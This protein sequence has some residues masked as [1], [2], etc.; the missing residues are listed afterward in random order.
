MAS[1]AGAPDIQLLEQG[2]SS[3]DYQ[4][5]EFTLTTTSWQ[6][7]EIS[8]V[9]E[10][11]VHIVLMVGIAGCATLILFALVDHHIA[12][13]IVGAFGCLLLASLCFLNYLR[14]CFGLC[15]SN[16]NKLVFNENAKAVQIF[17]NGAF[18]DS[19]AFEEY[20][21]LAYEDRHVYVCIAPQFARMNIV[22]NEYRCEP[23]R[24][25]E[26]VLMVHDIW[27]MIKRKH[28]TAEFQP[29]TC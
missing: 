1:S 6:R 14:H 27:A 24:G 3:S 29:V 12:Y 2:A 19:V 28:Q 7:G 13:E 21:G 18:V 4:N 17:R 23:Q 10:S 22:L 26:F 11:I 8:F 20:D 25:K 5:A 9:H 15:F 16:E